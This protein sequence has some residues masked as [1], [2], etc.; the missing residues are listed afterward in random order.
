[1]EDLQLFKGIVISYFEGITTGS[2][3]SKKELKDF[4][5]YLYTFLYKKESSLMFM[6]TSNVRMIH[7]EIQI[8]EKTTKLYLLKKFLLK[9]WN[10]VYGKGNKTH[11]QNIRSLIGFTSESEFSCSFLLLNCNLHQTPIFRYTITNKT[12]IYSE[13]D[14]KEHLMIAKEKVEK[15]DY[16]HYFSKKT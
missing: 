3:L 5:A 7:N 13:W 4:I 16:K 15:I 6:D 8:I 12:C 9:Y 2:L 11:L 14:Q 10:H 1:L